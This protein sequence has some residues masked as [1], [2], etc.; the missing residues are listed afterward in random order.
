VSLQ[1]QWSRADEAVTGYPR[2][3]AVVGTTG[4]GKTTLARGLSLRLELPHVELDALYWEPNWTEAP[5][6]LFRRRAEEALA[7]SG[8]VVDGNYGKVRDIVWGRAELLVWLD[9]AL[10]VIVQR[11]VSRTLRRVITREVLWN[12]NQER[13][14]DLLFS[15][16]ALWLWALKSYRR[17]RREYPVLFDRAEYRHLVVVRLRSPGDCQRWLSSVERSP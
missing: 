7:G 11:L 9:Y 14:R 15:R 1:S 4:S 12:G 16:D 10:P 2:R 17:K 5:V 13:W 8:W 6:D 3:I